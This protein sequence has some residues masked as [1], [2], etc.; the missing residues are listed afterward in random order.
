MRTR[1]LG[2]AAAALVL[3]AVAAGADR[4]EA[5]PGDGTDCKTCHAC[6]APTAADPCLKGCPRP[7]K[8]AKPPHGPT[9]VILDELEKIYDPVRFN[10]EA[11]AGMTR[12]GGDCTLC[13]HH[14]PEGGEH[15]ACRTC[16]PADVPHESSDQPGLKGAYHRQCLGC[17]REWEGETS[18]EICHTRKAMGGSPAATFHGKRERLELQDLIVFDTEYAEGDKVPFHHKNHSDRYES[19]CTSCHEDQSCTGCHVQNRT[20]HPMGSLADVDLH[21]ACFRCHQQSQ[22]TSHAKG[23]CTHCHGR[24]DADLFRHETTGWALKRYHKDLGCRA[25]HPSWVT[26]VKLD[27]SC[28]ACHPRGWGAGFDHDVTGVKLDDMHGEMDCSDCHEDGFGAGKSPSCSDCHDDGRK[29]D[30]KRG[31][32]S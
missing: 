18:C 31:F 21:D 30:P 15:P 7:K 25:C 32:G 4:A 2:A 22:G 10:H 16:H 11:H 3:L 9:V 26:P 13:H 23:D 27:R 24:A 12:F 6:P 17:H 20:P 8:A 1:V 28:A 14:T 19:D 29:Y 5:K